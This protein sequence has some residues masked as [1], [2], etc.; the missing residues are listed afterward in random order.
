[1]PERF[2]SLRYTDGE[3]QIQ[4]IGVIE[5]LGDFPERQQNLVRQTLAKQYHQQI[6][7]R[8]KHVKC[9]YGWLLT[10]TVQTNRGE[11][12]FLMRWRQDRAEAHGPKGK[13]LLD[14]YDNRYI[15]PDVGALPTKDRRRFLSYIYW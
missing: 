14:L 15:I 2:V 5:N 3:D 8:I 1:D 11:E 7:Q 9:E 10:F 12:R 6:I 13:V 4:E